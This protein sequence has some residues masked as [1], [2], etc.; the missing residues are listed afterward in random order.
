M[1]PFIN[2]TTTDG[3]FCRIPVVFEVPLLPAPTVLH[4][5][6]PEQSTQTSIIAVLRLACGKPG[7]PADVQAMCKPPP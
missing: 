4:V 6:Q 5:Q 7:G 3:R 2:R 1:G